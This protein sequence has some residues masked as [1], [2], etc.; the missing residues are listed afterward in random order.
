MQK[1]LRVRCILNRSTQ[2]ISVLDAIVSAKRES[3]P[4]SKSSYPHQKEQVGISLPAFFA[5][6]IQ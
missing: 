1:L 2:V 4:G 6:G 3:L 5:T